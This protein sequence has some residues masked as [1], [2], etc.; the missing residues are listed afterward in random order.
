[1]KKKSFLF[2]ILFPVLVF[3]QN[4]KIFERL[5]ALEDN[6]G[7]IWYNIDGYSI[8]KEVFNSEFNEKG[9]KKLYRKHAITNEDQKTKNDSIIINNLHVLKEKKISDSLIE[10]NSYYFLENPNKSTTLIWF[11]KTGDTDLSMEQTLVNLIIE[12][13]IPKENFKSMNI[14][15]LDFAGR[16]IDLGKNNCY[17]TFL[18]TV[19]CPDYGEMNWSIHKSLVDAKQSIK[20]QILLTLSRKG[21]KIDSEEWVDVEFEGVSTKAKKIIYSFKGIKSLITKIYGGNTLTIY[22]VADKVRDKYISCV[23]SFWNDEASST[24]LS[25]L[26]DKIMSLK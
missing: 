14:E 12:N 24:G 20:N 9:L 5:S 4:E 15:I 7:K 19:Q 17:W 21:G 6:N 16:P 2:L 18:N 25:P 22:Y 1:M 23:L 11:G 13:K 8:S 26:L 3:A 10:K